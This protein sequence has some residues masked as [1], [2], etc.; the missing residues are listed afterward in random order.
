MSD[1]IWV[2]EATSMVGGMFETCPAGTHPGTVVALFDCGTHDSGFTNKDGS[3]KNSRYLFVALELAKTD[4][5]GKPFVFL[6]R[7]TWSMHVDSN[8]RAMV[9][10]LTG[11]KFADGEQFDPRTLVGTPVMV[12]VVHDTKKDKTYH[13]AAGLTRFPDAFPRPT[14]TLGGGAWSV[15]SG[16][17]FPASCKGWLPFYYGESIDM[18]AAQAIE[19]RGTQ[20]QAQAPAPP[21]PPAPTPPPSPQVADPVRQTLTQMDQAQAPPAQWGQTHAGKLA[22]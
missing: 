15:L 13:S 22:F 9:E 3:R 12:S 18:I 20:P 7:Y 4:S 6:H 2:Q 17:P 11:R 19:L 5:N 1:N 21:A 16:D 8:W 14:Q 10:V